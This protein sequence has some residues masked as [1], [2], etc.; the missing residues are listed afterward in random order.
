M[1]VKYGHIQHFPH[2]F[3]VTID[4]SKFLISPNFEGKGFLGRIFVKKTKKAL[5]L[6]LLGGAFFMGHP[7]IY[8]IKIISKISNL[9]YYFK[10]HVCL[11][12]PYP[13]SVIP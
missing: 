13:F 9:K 8:S 12:F 1:L 10:F 3:L 5:I 11:S 6:I 4:P 2:I 7:V